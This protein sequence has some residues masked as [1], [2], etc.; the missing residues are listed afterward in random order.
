MACVIAIQSCLALCDS[1]TAAHP[2]SSVHSI[3][4]VRILEWVA[5]SFS[6]GSQADAL[7]SEPPGKNPL[8]KNMGRTC[9]EHLIL[10]KAVKYGG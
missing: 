8:L 5:I 9:L 2:G 6:K 1:W 4:Q 3:L 7:Q 10:A